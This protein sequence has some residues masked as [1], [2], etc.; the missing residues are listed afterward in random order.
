MTVCTNPIRVAKPFSRPVDVAFDA[1]HS[2]SDGGALLLRAVDEKLGLSRALAELLP[3][4]RDAR[5]VRHSR[6]EQ[7]LQRVLQMALGYED[8][9]DADTLRDDPALRLAC[10][11]HAGAEPLSS[12]PSLSRFENAVTPGAIAAMVRHLEQSWVAALPPDTKRVVLDIDSTDD[13]THGH[14][15][16]AL[17]HGFYEQ[18]MYHPLL[19][20]DGQTG[21]LISVMLRGGCAHAAKGAAGPLRRLICAVKAR[22]PKCHV[23]VRGDSAFAMPRLMALL[24]RLHVQFDD[25]DFV[26]GLARNSRLEAILRP[27]MTLAEEQFRAQPA[28]ERRTVRRFSAFRHEVASWAI[29]RR[30]IG[31]AE[32]GSKGAN[33]R[34]V[35]TT[36]W[37]ETPQEVYD[38]Y[39][40]RGQAENHIKDFK[41]GLKADRLSCSSFLA[42]FFRLLLHAAAYRLLFEVRAAASRHNDEV[43]RMEFAN[44]RLR[45]LKVAAL[46]GQSVRRVLV[47][48]PASFGRAD[49]FGRLLLEL[50]APSG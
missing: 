20:F 50:A 7:V 27:E 39:C 9:N 15:Q 5:R 17:F 14:Q 35:V 42:N 24:D 16:L 36:L 45:L 41:R 44:L 49:L 38:W 12:Q 10:R 46:V 13:P 48:L 28:A 47:R 30:V 37:E 29:D 31:K 1:P 25:V 21:Q 8:C 32:F 11:G 43:G 33:P 3:D 19:V 23:V 26:F 6:R 4:A 22:F 2:S 18:H 34:F 40:D